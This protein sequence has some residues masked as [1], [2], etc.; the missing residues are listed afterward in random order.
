MESASVT[1][2]LGPAACAAGKSGILAGRGTA[3]VSMI[4]AMAGE[5][6]M[7][8][9]SSS[10]ESVVSPQSDS[11]SD[12]PV[13]YDEFSENSWS[14]ASGSMMSCCSAEEKMVDPPTEPSVRDP[15]PRCERRPLERDRSARG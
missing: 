6:M 11:S 13:Q 10:I 4:S 9:S 5:S 3:R 7:G 12:S 14:L 8:I 2:I 1:M 15:E